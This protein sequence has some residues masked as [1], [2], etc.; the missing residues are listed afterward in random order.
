[1]I[2]FVDA[3][4]R[5]ESRTRRLAE[6]VLSN[7]CKKSGTDITTTELYKEELRPVDRALIEVRDKALASGD[8][9]SPVFDM[10]R[11]FADA[12]I[13]IV[14]APYWDFSFP[15]ILKT[16]FENIS[17]NGICFEYDD[18]GV[19]HGLCRAEKLYYVTTSGGE[20]GKMNFGYDYVKALVT[21]LYGIGDTAC[22][23]AVGLDLIGN[24]PEVILKNAEEQLKTMFEEDT[25]G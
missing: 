22:I 11:Q 18:K 21:G 17:V 14:A 13:I 1:M 16:Y 2:L 3:C 6:M 23:R 20:I 25:L 5:E 15:A 7:V 24:D 19:P 8:F 10:A 12:D 4:A 9:S